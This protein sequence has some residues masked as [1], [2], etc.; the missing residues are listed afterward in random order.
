MFQ[1]VVEIIGW[2]I[3][4]FSEKFCIFC[5][6]NKTGGGS[7]IL[8]PSF[9]KFTLVTPFLFYPPPHPPCERVQCAGKSDH[10]DCTFE[11]RWKTEFLTKADKSD[12]KSGKVRTTFKL[13]L[14]D[15]TCWM[16]H[17]LINEL[18]WTNIELKF[19]FMK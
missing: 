15:Q 14:F 9:F 11:T 19:K 1:E 10:A 12:Y 7:L 5:C 13:N 4:V 2:G 3:L 16:I 6:K 8:F 18:K 17:A